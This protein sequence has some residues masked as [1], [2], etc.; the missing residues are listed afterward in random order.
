MA[1]S[2]YGRYLA[3]FLLL[4]L[5]CSKQ[6]SPAAQ[7]DGGVD[8]TDNIDE[9]DFC[10]DGTLNESEQ[11]DDGN[12]NDH[13]GCSKDCEIEGG[14]QCPTPGELCSPI[15]DCVEGEYTP[16]TPLEWLEAQQAR[17][18][19]KSLVTS[20]GEGV[21]ASNLHSLFDSN[22]PW[23]NKVAYMGGG[24][25]GWC[26]F[27]DLTFWGKPS[28]PRPVYYTIKELMKYLKAY[29]KA[30]FESVDFQDETTIHR[31]D[32]TKNN[33]GHGIS[34]V[35]YDDRIGQLHGDDIPAMPHEFVQPGYSSITKID[36]IVAPGQTEFKPQM[37]V[38]D[39]DGIFNITVTETPSLLVVN[40]TSETTGEIDF[41][42]GM[43]YT[44][45]CRTTN[46]EG[47]NLADI[48]RVMGATLTKPKDG[49]TNMVSIL[50]NCDTRKFDFIKM[51]EIV[52]DWQSAGYEFLIPLSMSWED[53]K[54][55]EFTPEEEACYRDYLR[56]FVERYDGDGQDDMPGLLAPIKYWQIE[57]EFRT[58]FFDIGAGLQEWENPGEEY[59]ILLE[60]AND[61]I[62]GEGGAYPEAKILTIPGQF[63]GIFRG[64]ESERLDYDNLELPASAQ[65]TLDNVKIFLSRPDLFDVVTYNNIADWSHTIGAARFFKS[66]MNEYGYSKPIIMSDM[67]YTVD[68]MLCIGMCMYPYDGI[69]INPF[70][71]GQYND[72]VAFLDSLG[73]NKPFADAGEAE[74]C[75]E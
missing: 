56:T 46:Q 68:P 12:T 26:G 58:G 30:T 16:K 33:T 7:E 61:V 74:A 6:Q 72:V 9:V 34:V 31:Y 2:N 23:Q 73:P 50:P 39:G 44:V 70:G 42:L 66:V 20:I 27:I 43:E 63:R 36:M 38:A 17:F 5:G 48:F 67:S 35:W 59:L 22:P 8:E 49:A 69:S 65:K 13:D 55:S 37:I 71:P 14:F 1:S 54:P 40:H 60:I 51:D 15:D 4:F 28:T 62:K 3:A 47:K 45:P 52:E 41:T 53:K 11:C 29:D 18:T 19:A 64:F 10:G 32:F 21:S 24:T 57:S 25:F 75:E